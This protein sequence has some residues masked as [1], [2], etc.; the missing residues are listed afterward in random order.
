M[1]NKNKNIYTIVLILG[2]FG[3]GFLYSRNSIRE[4][5]EHAKILHT[6]EQSKIANHDLNEN[7]LRLK[8][9]LLQTYD[10]LVRDIAKLRDICKRFQN[11]SIYRVLRDGD[12]KEFL[13]NYC[14]SL[15]E[16]DELVEQ[17]KTQHSVLRNSI[18]YLP[19]V[20]NGLAKSKYSDITH[21]LFSN[22]TLYN[23]DRSDVLEENIYNLL[24]KIP[25]YP[26]NKNE[27]IL[28]SSLKL[29]VKLMVD[30]SLTRSVLE[31]KILSNKVVTNLEH[32]EG[33]Y[34]E[35]YQSQQNRA[36]VFHYLLIIVCFGL[37]IWL[38]FIF[39]R[40]QSLTDDLRNLNGS[41]EFKVQTRTQEL[42]QAINK[43][44]ENQTV[45]TQ[46][47]KMTALGEMA[48]GIAHEINTPL[49]AILMNAE[50][51]IDKADT[52]HNPE[53]IRKRADAIV[54]IVGRV[55]KIISGLKRFSRNADATERSRV[56]VQTIVD[57]TLALC[58][59]K[60]KSQSVNLKIKI[61]TTDMTVHCV[62]EHISQVLL[63]FLNNSLYALKDIQALSGKWIT[64]N[65]TKKDDKIEITVT[66]AGPGL[67]ESVQAKLMQPFFTT[68][69][70]GAGTGLGLSISRGIIEQNGGEMFYDKTCPNTRFV[71]RL[72]A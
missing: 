64:I 1:R 71:I 12:T 69:P 26:K 27:G 31:E 41:L 5:S 67:P 11:D 60:F 22:A 44:A 10:P 40:L 37:G 3:L 70:P 57:D 72:P 53:Q 36:V 63:N 24:K 13:N 56:L 65:A 18:K 42:S 59:E 45:L 39:Q 66:D 23:F 58:S 2:V 52:E 17:Y 35:N 62:P 68:K 46:S 25:K 7:V 47:A 30:Y 29:H 21:A 50:M 6:F 15:K 8:T 4:I 34:L 32:L 16:K 54:K 43:L 51:L 9:F 48:G 19:L 14:Q 55:S 33:S 20:V 38:V 28:L 49:S 61:E